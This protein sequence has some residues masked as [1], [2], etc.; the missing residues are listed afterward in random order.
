MYE[1]QEAHLHGLLTQSQKEE[2]ANRKVSICYY[3]HVTP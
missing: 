2:E 3:A 1:L